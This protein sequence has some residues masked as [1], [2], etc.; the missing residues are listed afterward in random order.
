MRIWYREV[1]NFFIIFFDEYLERSNLIFIILF[2]SAM[3]IAVLYYFIIWRMYQ[4]QLY[5]LLKNSSDLINLIPQE[6]KNIIFE[7]I[8]E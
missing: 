4:E 2:I 5:I 6:I 7:M 8:N 3:V 1:L